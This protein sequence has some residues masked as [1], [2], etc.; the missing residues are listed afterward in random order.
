MFM[1]VLLEQGLFMMGGTDH[2]GMNTV[3][4]DTSAMTLP[5]R[6]LCSAVIHLACPSIFSI[7]S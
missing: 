3:K 5:S 4:Y 2:A 6:C 7:D 1:F